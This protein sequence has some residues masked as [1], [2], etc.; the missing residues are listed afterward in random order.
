MDALAY[1]NDNDD[2]DDVV[3]YGD[4]NNVNREAEDSL[5]NAS[6]SQSFSVQDAVEIIG[7]GRFN[8]RLFFLVGLVCM[9]DAMEML[10]LSFVSPVVSCEWN[11]SPIEEASLSM[12]VFGGM[13]VGALLWGYVSDR[14]G[15]KMAFVIGTATT[16]VFAA[17]SA[18]SLSFGMLLFTRFMVGAGVANS[19]VAFS[20]LSEFLPIGFRGKCLMWIEL[21]WTLGTVLEVGL[22]W[23][24]LSSYGWRVL[25]AVSAIPAFVALVL[26]P[27]LPES[28][29]FL[30]VSGRKDDALAILQSA[31]ATNKA[32]LPKGELSGG[33]WASKERAS[34]AVFLTKPMMRLLVPLCVIWFANSFIYYGLVLFTTV[35]LSS[36]DDSGSVSTAR[37]CTISNDVFLQ[38]LITTCSEVP[39]LVLSVYG[40]ERYGRRRLMAL[41][42]AITSLSIV[43]VSAPFNSVFLT[44]SLSVGRAAIYGAFAVVYV[45]TPEAFPT[46][47]RALGL[48]LCSA[49]ARVGG[50]LSP[51]VANGVLSNSLLVPVLLYGGCAAVAA[52]VSLYLPVETSG[53]VLVDETHHSRHA[54]CDDSGQDEGFLRNAE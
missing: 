37:V 45:Y 14:L 34:F 23:A 18:A 26:S 33:M 54:D 30:I 10:L 20:L 31:A 13:M 11:L 12:V 35:A 16:G 50:V 8:V 29:R 41:Q 17:L 42:M 19:A 4:H 39:G 3:G 15:R 24:V 6:G 1:M 5:M 22:A 7:F 32:L 52:I 25:L 49:F 36:E 51:I 9:S 2:D 21:F 28:P 46:T 43:L 44:V 47:V 40:L 38:I 53:K 27:M 48:G